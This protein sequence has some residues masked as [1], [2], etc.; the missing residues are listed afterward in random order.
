[1]LKIKKGT[2]LKEVVCQINPVDITKKSYT[3]VF[4]LVVGKNGMTVYP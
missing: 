3:K 4:Y 1:M 2:S